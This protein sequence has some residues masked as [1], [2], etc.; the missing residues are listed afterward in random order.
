MRIMASSPREDGFFMPGEFEPHEGTLMLWP[1]RPDNWRNGAK[2]AQAAFMRVAEAISRF[3]PVTMGVSAAQYDNA[4]ALLPPGVRV[5][6]LSHDDS[7][8]R[9]CGPTFVKNREGALRGVKWRFNAYGGLT[10]GLYFPWDKDDRVGIKVCE[11]EKAD[12]YA[13]DDFVL[14]GGSIHVD[15]EGTAIVTEAC[16][17]SP[18]RNPNLSKAQI[19]E[20]LK[21]FL[22]VE[23][24]I[25]LKHGILGDETN[26]HVDNVCAFVKPGEVVLAMPQDKTD[27]QYP[28]FELSLATL[29]QETDARGRKL[30]IHKLP[31]PSPLVITEE[32]STGVDPVNRFCPRRVGD[33]MAGSYVNYYV[34]NG[35][36][37]MPGFNDPQDER[38]RQLLQELYPDRA[39]V[40]IYSREILLGGGNI[41][42]ITQQIPKRGR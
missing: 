23:K 29:E 4:R 17:L 31:L 14:E 38:A 36:V 7:W 5:V 19:E 6:E 3:E 12:Y 16:L 8:M 37:V 1:E 40:Q 2:P 9:D 27:P 26:E 24:V 25:W 41:H 22:T 42:C 18:G 21:R 39:V 35:A 34:C 15:G 10:D 32:E 20:R 28:L 11:M 13:P 30:K 33:R